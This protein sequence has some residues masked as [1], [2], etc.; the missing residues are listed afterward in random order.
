MRPL[1]ISIALLCFISTGVATAAEDPTPSVAITM[2]DSLSFG[3]KSPSIDLGALGIW[4]LTPVASGLTYSQNNPTSGAGDISNAQ[5]LIQKTE[6][7]FQFFVQ[8]GLYSVPV[9]G[10]PMMR[11]LSNTV[12]TYG[13]IP[14]ASVSYI[15]DKNWSVT[16]GKLPSMGGYES[17]MTFQ[18]LNIQR[19]LLWDQTSSVSYG[20]VVNYQKDDLSFAVTWNDG[21]YSNRMNWFGASGAYQLNDRESLGFSWVGSVS[22][23][24]QNNYNTPLLQ[25]NSQILNALYKYSGDKWFIA[26]YL[27]YT[28]IPMNQAIGITSEYQTYGAALLAS[29][30][31]PSVNLSGFGLAKMS[32]PFRVEYIQEKGGTANN[33]NSVLYGPNS[34]AVSL[35]ITPTIQIDGY[36]ARA[37]GSVVQVNGLEPGL[38]F[39]TNNT[40]RSQ[41]RVM[42]EVGLLY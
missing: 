9:L 4:Q 26:P 41:Y 34:S 17:T 6:G 16:A 29:Y 31:L 35:T 23:N 42:L 11:T 12:D 8:T 20:T 19:G 24:S 21:Y 13:Y 10:K 37:E 7:D 15:L 2:D 38:G 14:N 30:K 36:F 22:G 28:L 25:N 33:V 40:N 32:V 3:G 39:G 1:D 18:N 5:L 27:Q